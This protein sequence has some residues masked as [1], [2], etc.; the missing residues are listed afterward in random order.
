MQ[1]TVGSALNGTDL[2][3][4]LANAGIVTGVIDALR[5]AFQDKIDWARFGALIAIGMGIA[6]SEAAVLLEWYGSGI[7]WQEGLLVGINV[8]LSA[9]GFNRMITQAPP[10]VVV[11]GEVRAG[12]PATATI[13]DPVAAD[14]RA[15]PRLAPTPSPVADRPSIGG[16]AR[17]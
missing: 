5:R 15:Q 7:T 3:T 2:I 8:G 14:G 4:I 10:T 16:N 13:P 11:Q 17:I 9:S 6:T 1:E 12:A